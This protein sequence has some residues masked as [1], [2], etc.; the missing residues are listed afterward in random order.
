MS[1]NFSIN[2]YKNR[3][4]C[5][6]ANYSPQK[7]EGIDAATKKERKDGKATT[8]LD[9]AE[10][11]V[12]YVIIACK[13]PIR[14]Q[15]RFEEL[16]FVAGIKVVVT[17]KAPFGDPL[18]LDIMGYSLCVRASEAKHITIAREQPCES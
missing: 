11:N 10:L 14:L 15:T 18:E 17:K 8:T 4:A 3:L 7:G 5:E 9:K 16:G 6:S 1:N 2:S 13:L 12:D